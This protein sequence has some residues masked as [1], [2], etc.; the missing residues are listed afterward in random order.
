MI[1]GKNKQDYQGIVNL[2][3]ILTNQLSIVIIIIVFVLK[4]TTS[5]SAFMS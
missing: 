1:Q 4:V 5:Q 2:S 3:I